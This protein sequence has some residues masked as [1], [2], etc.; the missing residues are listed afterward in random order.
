MATLTVTITEDLTLNGI[1]QGGTVTDT[2]ASIASVYKR[3]ITC[4]PNVD[5]TIASFQADPHTAS[6]PHFD[7]ETTKYI[8]VTN[9]SSDDVVSLSLQIAAAGGTSAADSCGISLQAGKSFILHNCNDGIAVNSAAATVI[10]TL[11][12]L[13]SIII[14]SHASNAQSIELFVAGT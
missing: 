12:D 3:I 11:L 6:G 2:E 5:T 4:A 8:R 9:L 10:T 7:R 1:Q 14:D 13:E